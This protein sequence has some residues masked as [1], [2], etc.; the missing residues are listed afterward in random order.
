MLDGSDT[1]CPS[2]EITFHPDDTIPPQCEATR[3]ID[4]DVE[5]CTL[6][7]GHDEPH[8]DWYPQWEPPRCR[9]VVKD[10]NGHPYKC[11]RPKDHTGHHVSTDEDGLVDGKLVMYQL[12][13]TGMRPAEATIVSISEW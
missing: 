4:G 3:M 10:P 9:A 7:R 2:C 8:G 12:E 1:Y 5:E 13:W 6:V 11:Q